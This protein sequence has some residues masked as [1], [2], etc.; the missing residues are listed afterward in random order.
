MEYFFNVK[1]LCLLSKNK[2]K[3][4]IFARYLRKNKFMKKLIFIL[5]FGLL[6]VFDSFAQDLVVDI[7]GNKYEGKI[8]SD[9]EEEVTIQHVSGGEWVTTRVERDN[10]FNHRY[11]V[12]L[13]KKMK[14]VDDHHA[15]TVGLF[16][17]GS[18][19]VGMEYEYYI[20]KGW[21]V[22]AG[23]GVMGASAG[24]NYHFFSSIRSSYVS[25]QYWYTGF[26]GSR[27]LYPLNKTWAWGY[28]TMM[29]GPSVTYR[30]KSWFTGTFGIGYIVDRGVAYKAP[31]NIPVGFK[32]SLGAYFTVK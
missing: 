2:Q 32:L 21:G 29:V 10:L 11:N 8:I 3:N 7:F 6:G 26:I 31:L 25:L 4:S 20:D 28:R 9:T 16:A 5:F 12:T 30:H 18:T 22:Q 17:G 19:L 15:F 14:G 27:S 23:V 1:N 24:V 13:D